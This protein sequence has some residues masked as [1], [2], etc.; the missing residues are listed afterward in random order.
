MQ[1]QDYE[2]LSVDYSRIE[3]I[4]LYLE[5]NF[6][7]QPDLRELADHIGLSEYHFQRLFSRWAGISPK[8]FLQFLTVEHA[9][10]R[11]ATSSD[12]LLNVTY[13]AG[14][15]SPGR[16]HD[17]FVTCEAMTPGEFKK[18]GQDVTI[19]YGF[20]P[21]PFGDCLLAAT[22]RGI[23]GLAF[24]QVGDRAYV[25]ADLKRRWPRAAF[26]EDRDSTQAFVAGIFSPVGRSDKPLPLF[27]KGTNF[28][29][30]VWQALLQ[31]PPGAVISYNDLAAHIG[32]PNAARAVGNAVGQN[33]ISYVIPC[34]RVIRKMGVVGNYHWGAARKKALLGREAAQ[35]YLPAA[36]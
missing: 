19:T 1:P 30:Q 13:D 4:I 2:Q 31:I 12:S 25:L 15:S 11:L 7:R 32:R 20:H 5:R 3:Q 34:H 27:L 22:D 8:R 29:L 14:L 35:Y 6:R 18:A 33:P 17:L 10:E 36:A 9:K 16:L 26:R 23:C 28:Q 24:S 21:S